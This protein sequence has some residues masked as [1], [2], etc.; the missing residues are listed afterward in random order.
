MKDFNVN[1]LDFL[2]LDKSELFCL[3]VSQIKLQ[4]E[5]EFVT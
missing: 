3:S 5:V 1:T 2:L 4:L